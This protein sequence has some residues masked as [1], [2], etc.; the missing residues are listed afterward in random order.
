MRLPIR[1]RLT[2]VSAA[3]MAAVLVG[4]AVFL[5]VRLEAD[6]VAAVDAGLRSRASV[7]EER[8]GEGGGVSGSGI[9]EADEAF[10]QLLTSDGQLIA[11]SANVPRADGRPRRA[12]R[13]GGRGVPREARGDGGGAGARPGCW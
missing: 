3:L 10:A 7:L 6:L 1:A 8:I 5:Y 9:A 4:L 11:S 13:R 2:L 12:E